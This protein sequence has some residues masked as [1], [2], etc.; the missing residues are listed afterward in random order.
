MFFHYCKTAFRYLWK[1]KTQSLTGI[2]GLAFG[3]ACF[4]PALYWLR[5]ETSYDSFYPDAAH[6]YR[7]YSVEKESGKVNEQVPGILERKLHEHFPAMETT[8]TLFLETNN[9]SAVRLP[10]KHSMVVACRSDYSNSHSGFSHRVRASVES[11]QQ[12]SCGGGEK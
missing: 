10:Y 9:C 1:Y 8:A 3:L 6:I 4:V 12:Q 7:V 5:Y 11:R 2:F